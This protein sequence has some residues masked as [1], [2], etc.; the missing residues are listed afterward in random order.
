GQRVG[1]DK[2]ELFVSTDP[3]QA[4][5]QEFARHTPDF[6][7]LHDVGGSASLHLLTAVAGA[8]GAP[9]QQLAIRRQGHG[10]A[11]ATLRFVEI[12]G[13]GSH[14]LRVYSTDA[15]ADTGARRLLANVLLG[16]SRLGVLMV[17]DLPSHALATALQPVQE[18]IRKGPWPNRNL[19]LVPRGA[20]Q[21]LSA[22]AAT[23]AAGSGVFV[24][25]TP[26]AAQ[27]NDAW[28]YI[29]GTWNRLRDTPAGQASPSAPVAASAP[30]E[31]MPLPAPEPVIRKATPTPA[32]APAVPDPHGPWQA[33]VKACSGVK[34][35]ISVCIFD[36]R[37]MRVL[38]HNNAR[39]DP[40]R[41]MT[42]G[43]ALFNTMANSGRS[44][45]LGSSQPDA[46]ISLAAHHL[47]L[48]PLPGHAG[49]LLHAVLDGSIANL[50]LARMQLQR[51]DTTVLGL[52]ARS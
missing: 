37:T 39:P 40:Q 38:A 42:Q 11:L 47:L 41:L 15:D 17:G 1:D 31:P 20:A 8:L 44:L 9:L 10:V 25:V 45:G 21:T 35:L 52:P 27:A 26:Q 32:P 12:P 28:T 7:A 16:H 50:T 23:L 6:I 13:R 36:T 2:L 22:Q 43:M 24:R 48:H 49:I 14:K 18:G 33:Y 5:L 29:T 34:G 3:A 19:L 46:A 30:T 51:V 4:L